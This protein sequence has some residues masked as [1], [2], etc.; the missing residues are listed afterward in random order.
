M[1]KEIRVSAKQLG[2]LALRYHCRRCFWVKAKMKGKLP[3][4]SFPGIFSS[5]DSYTK[6]AVL[7]WFKRH[8]EAP[9]WLKELGELK[10]CIDP[11]GFRKFF[12]DDEKIG[13]RLT[14]SPDIFFVREDGKLL[15]VDYKTSKYTGG[16]QKL[17]PLYEVQLNAYAYIASRVSK[18]F[19]Y[20]EV[21]GLALLYT[22]PVTEGERIESDG[23]HRDEHLA[24]E[25]KATPVEI[26]H[27]EDRLLNLLDV[28]RSILESKEPPKS[29]HG[30]HECERVGKLADLTG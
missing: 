11:P 27:R 6:K 23:L 25:F 18:Q 14:G 26:E 20:P 2:E 15:I 1:K 8:K 30:C 16:Q 21:G 5:I 12:V 19:G 28:A 7:G 3:Y 9:P 22:E 4:Q 17:M 24:M 29:R 10:E 13:I